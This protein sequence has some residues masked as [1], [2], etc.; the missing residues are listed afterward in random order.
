MNS[1]IFAEWKVETDFKNTRIDYYLKKKFKSLSYPYVCTLLRKGLVKVNGKKVKN[2]YHLCLDDIIRINKNLDLYS[3]EQTNNYISEK[4]KKIIRSWLIYKDKNYIAINKPSGIAVQG[5]TKVKINVD[6]ILEGLRFSAKEKP[7]LI[8]RLDKQTSGILILARSLKS[9]AFAGNLF[10]NRKIK[11]TYLAVLHGK[12]LRTKGKI[13]IPIINKDKESDAMTL[14]EILCNSNNLSL[15]KINPLTGRKH[16]I[17]K[18]FFLK[19]MPILGET[20]FIK[21]SEK[22]KLNDELFLHA[23]K[24]EFISLDGKKIIIRADLPVYF[25]RILEKNNITLDYSKI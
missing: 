6:G 3:E 21:S 9:A 12:V 20:K 11:K 8:H 14:Y 5:G 16:Q 19:G 22:K 1:S 2:T 10:K 18:H 17:R 15:V 13:D 4:Y 7:K 24:T 23:F 25:K